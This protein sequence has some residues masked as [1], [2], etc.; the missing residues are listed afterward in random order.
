MKPKRA[1]FLALALAAGCASLTQEVEE[2]KAGWLGTPYEEVLA[3]WGSPAR[4]TPLADGRQ[5]H[6]WISQEQ[7]AYGGGPQVGVGVYGGSG[8]GV[9]VGMG[10]PFGT[11]VNP[12]RCERTLIFRDGLVAEQHWS[13]DEGYCRWFKK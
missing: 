7:P 1:V 8:V 4:S 2:A 10:F 12:A 13:G 9:G 6:T 11:T 3:R 5:S